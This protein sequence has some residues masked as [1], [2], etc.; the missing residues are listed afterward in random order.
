MLVSFVKDKEN[1]NLTKVQAFSK[2]VL[3][4]IL[5]TAR[6]ISAFLI[7]NNRMVKTKV[8]KTLTI[9]SLHSIV[10]MIQTL[11]NSQSSK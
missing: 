1:N 10:M 5:S 6:N 4:A 11:M 7:T 3:V 2:A 9:S 8:S